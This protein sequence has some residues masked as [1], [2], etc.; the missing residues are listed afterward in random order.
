MKTLMISACRQLARL[1]E[2][3]LNDPAKYE[4]EIKSYNVRYCRG[5][6]R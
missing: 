5:W 2:M 4:Q 6:E 3:K 1:L